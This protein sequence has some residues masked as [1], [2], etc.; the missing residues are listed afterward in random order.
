MKLHAINKKQPTKK[1]MG[2]ESEKPQRR[3]AKNITQKPGC[4]QEM[5]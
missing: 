3:K 1:F 4:G 5:T 2:R